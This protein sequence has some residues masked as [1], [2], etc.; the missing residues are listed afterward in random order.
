MFEHITCFPA[1]LVLTATLTITEPTACEV[2]TV[3]S[4]IRFDEMAKLIADQKQVIKNMTRVVKEASLKNVVHQQER[5]I[6]DQSNTIQNLT[7]EQMLLKTMVDEQ[8][9]QIVELNYTQNAMLQN[10]NLLKTG[11][12]FFF[13]EFLENTNNTDS[14]I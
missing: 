1:M 12:T 13:C 7:Q 14:L 4:I 2:L 11:K 6:D 10:V 8:K 5:I 9:V 3:S